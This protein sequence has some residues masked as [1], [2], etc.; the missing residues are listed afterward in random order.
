[1]VPISRK[2]KQSQCKISALNLRSWE[3]PKPYP[4]YYSFTLQMKSYIIF[5]LQNWKPSLTHFKNCEIVQRKREMDQ[6]GGVV[7]IHWCHHQRNWARWWLSCWT[8]RIQPCSV[9]DPS[10][11]TRSTT[12]VVWSKTKRVSLSL[13]FSLPPWMRERGTREKEIGER[14]CLLLCWDL[15]VTIHNYLSFF[16]PHTYY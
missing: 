13:F 16:G 14:L 11:S 8:N 5:I 10:S 7:Y 9:S 4:Y 3:D 12:Q 2:I 1:M 15:F 6:K